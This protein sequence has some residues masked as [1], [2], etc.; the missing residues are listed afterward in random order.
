VK[1][2]FFILVVIVLSGSLLFG[3]AT[4]VVESTKVNAESTTKAAEATST[5]SSVS[6]SKE[7]VK[8]EL[9]TWQWVE[10]QNQP[11]FEAF[12]NAFNELYPDIELTI[13]GIAS[14]EYNQKLLTRVSAGDSPDVFAIRPTQIGQLI[15][16]GALQNLDD[17]VNQASWKKNLATSQQ[18][19]VKDGSYYAIIFTSTP[20]A[21]CY[22]K[23]IFEEAGVSVPKTVDELYNTAQTIFEKT[24]IFGFG[25]ATDTTNIFQMNLESRKW[26]SGFGGDWADG[27]NPTA[28]SKETIEGVK[29]YK[30][31]FD[32]DFTPK[33]QT[34]VTLDQMMWEGK[35]AMMI[36]GAWLFGAVKTKNPDIYPSIDAALPPT[37]TQA[38]IVG[39]AFFGVDS[40]S[41]NKDAAWK[42]ID[43]YNSTEWQ[44]KYV[45]MTAQLPGQTGMITDK[46]LAEKPWWK[47]FDEGVA[48][49][50]A[51]YG[52]M[53]PGFELVADEYNNEIGIALADI[54]QGGANV[55]DRLNK[56]QDTLV[57]KFVK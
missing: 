53:A 50:L 20:Q 54:L 37:P 30:K 1:K 45:E 26:V 57:K 23:K 28:N 39:G 9:F 33:G 7:K 19:G 44:Q 31:L 51:A 43:L 17:W 2:I 52:Y 35:L 36:E 10:P 6:E 15:D 41:K 24:G 11:Y 25:C 14:G 38:T 56:L 22:N 21:L 5:V 16:L 47:V 32:A 46:V 29:F 27:K 4:P 34:T 55:E 18:P 49:H 13:S 12:K 3:C 48:K 42:V 8:I 40:N